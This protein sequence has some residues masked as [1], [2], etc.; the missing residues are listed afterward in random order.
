MQEPYREGAYLAALQVGRQ[1]PLGLAMPQA[2]IRRETCRQRRSEGT[3]T[4]AGKRFSLPS[5]H[6][7]LDQVAIGYAAWDLDAVFLVHHST[8]VIF[9]ARLGPVGN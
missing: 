9:R 3:L 5:R 4:V 7:H 8:D 2:F 1:A 6:R